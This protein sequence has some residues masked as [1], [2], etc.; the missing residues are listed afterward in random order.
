MTTSRRQALRGFTATAA[1]ATVAVA[2]AVALSAC[3][4]VK[5][6]LG[7]D[8][9]DAG[10][11]GPG[12][13]SQDAEEP[14]SP[15]AEETATEDT[16]TTD[17]SADDGPAMPEPEGDYLATG[18]FDGINGGVRL[19]ITQSDNG[20]ANGKNFDG[21]MYLAIGVTIDAESEQLLS[22][23]D[24]EITYLD[25][26]FVPGLDA[27]PRMPD[28]F[29]PD[30]LENQTLTGQVECTVVFAVADQEMADGYMLQMGAW[31]EMNRFV[32]DV[33]QL[34]FEATPRD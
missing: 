28:P 34:E 20:D 22:G 7:A 21:A 24:F 10:D 27:L 15:A 5:T 2:V 25:G 12:E 9:P 6:L 30:H 33:L 1:A 17:A 13:G 3:G 29:A 32:E 26:E 31:V 18:T 23:N 4:S 14:A 16:D 19:T 8:E 11:G